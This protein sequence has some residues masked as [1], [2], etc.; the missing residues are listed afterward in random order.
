VVHSKGV[1]WTDFADG[2]EVWGKLTV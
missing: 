2:A 1:L